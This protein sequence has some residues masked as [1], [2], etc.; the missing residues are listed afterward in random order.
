MILGANVVFYS[1]VFG[2][3]YYAF[4]EGNKNHPARVIVF[5]VCNKAASAILLIYCL[6]NFSIIVKKMRSKEF[7]TSERLMWI[8]FLIFALSI[9]A[10][11]AILICVVLIQNYSNSNTR[12]FCRAYA[13]QEFF[14]NLMLLGSF[15]MI[16]LFI[17]LSVKFSEPLRDYRKKFLLLFQTNNLDRV[18]EVRREHGRATRYNQ[19]AIRDANLIIIRALTQQMLVESTDAST[20]QEEETDSEK[21]FLSDLKSDDARILDDDSDLKRNSDEILNEV[22]IFEF[23]KLA[24]TL[25]RPVSQNRPVSI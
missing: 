6:V 17:F 9:L 1:L 7:F 25:S 19:I 24:S 3:L 12:A 14:I 13:S 20:P 22:L 15:S 5:D 8:H 18:V 11:I 4:T 23:S 16:V 21:S 10:Y 2:Y